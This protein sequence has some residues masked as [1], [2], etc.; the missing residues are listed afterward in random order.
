MKISNTC[1]LKIRRDYKHMMIL[2]Y[3]I[4]CNGVGMKYCDVYKVCTQKLR[5]RDD[6]GV[7]GVLTKVSNTR[8]DVKHNM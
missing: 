2:H 4:I 7:F 3:L 8:H 5:E 6:V 1:H